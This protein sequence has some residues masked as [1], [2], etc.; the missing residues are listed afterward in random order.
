MEKNGKLFEKNFYL[1]HMIRAERYLNN[2][3]NHVY[4]LKIGY[5]A[6]FTL[7]AKVQLSLEAPTS[8]LI[9]LKTF[10]K[11][12]RLGVAVIHSPEA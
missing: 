3:K 6:R 11:I 10:V 8:D 4:L 1:K 5:F 9:L 7:L 2:N 12:A